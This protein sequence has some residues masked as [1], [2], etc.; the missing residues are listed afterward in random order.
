M[1]SASLGPSSAE[2][3]KYLDEVYEGLGDFHDKES[4]DKNQR[5]AREKL[6]AAFSE[7]VSFENM[8]RDHVENNRGEITVGYDVGDSHADPFTNSINLNLEE[9]NTVETTYYSPERDEIY[10]APISLPRLLIHESIHLFM[11]SS[12]YATI[13]DDAQSIQPN[14]NPSTLAPV[15]QLTEESNIAPGATV[16]MT[17][18]ILNE[19]NSLKEDP[20]IAYGSGTDDNQALRKKIDKDLEDGSLDSPYLSYDRAKTVPNPRREF[21]DNEHQNSPE[22]RST[23][24]DFLLANEPPNP[25]KQD[26]QQAHTRDTLI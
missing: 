9:I 24:K 21:F 3:L 7:S 4:G 26:N 12:D 23:S 11:N 17:N 22:I 13:E 15:N 14:V 2:T 19:T 16:R 6:I 25:V 18:S 20:R 1:T 8:V 10:Q 5:L